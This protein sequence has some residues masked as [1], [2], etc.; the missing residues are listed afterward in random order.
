MPKVMQNVKQLGFEFFQQQPIASPRKFI[1][2]TKINDASDIELLN[3][4]AKSEDR[5]FS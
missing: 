4:N 5:I 2:T 1:D 3:L